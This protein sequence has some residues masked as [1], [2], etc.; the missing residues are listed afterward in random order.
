MG[1]ERNALLI[2]PF[3]FGLIRLLYPE[4]GNMLIMVLANLQMTRDE[5]IVQSHVRFSVISHIYFH[6]NTDFIY[7]QYPLLKL[8]A[9]YLVNQTLTAGFQ[10]VFTFSLMSFSLK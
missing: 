8:W 2:L 4:S 5:S 9:D 7:F 1:I 3:T 10:Y 6:F